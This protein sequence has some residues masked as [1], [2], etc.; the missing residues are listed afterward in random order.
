MRLSKTTNHAIRVLIEC[1]GA[2]NEL[3]KVADLSERLGITKQNTFKIVHLLSRSGFIKAE[4]GRNG[5]VRLAGAA[6]SI[7]MGQ[8]VRAMEERIATAAVNS[9]QDS[10]HLGEIVDDALDAFTSVL[11]GYSIADMA[12]QSARSKRRNG[13]GKA[14]EKKRKKAKIKTATLKKTSPRSKTQKSGARR[15]QIER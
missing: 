13:V 1:A 14:D 3:L 5:G 10:K 6:N 12:A 2:E 8:V 4:R 9:N 11:D 15:R 7:Q